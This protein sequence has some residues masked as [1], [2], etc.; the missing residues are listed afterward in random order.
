MYLYSSLAGDQNMEKR[1]TKKD[2]EYYIKIIN[3]E[4]K[5]INASIESVNYFEKNNKFQIV[6]TVK[7]EILD[8]GWY[9]LSKKDLYIALKMFYRQIKNIYCAN[10][11]V[12]DFKVNNILL[13]GLIEDLNY[14]HLRG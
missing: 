2:L 7:G 4:I 3:S 1:V 6:Y 11:I 12:T 8:S 14:Y 10:N 13:C 5:G 9:K